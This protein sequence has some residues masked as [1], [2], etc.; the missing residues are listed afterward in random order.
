MAER[1]FTFCDLCC[2]GMSVGHLIQN[3]IGRG[4]AEWSAEH[5]VVE[6]GWQRRGEQIVCPECLEDEEAAAQPACP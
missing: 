3:G 6:F 1:V 5:C 4:W 2:D